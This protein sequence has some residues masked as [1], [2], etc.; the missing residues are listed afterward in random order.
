M[1]LA[2]LL[3]DKIEFITPNK[4]TSGHY[5]SPLM[6]EAAEIVVK[7]HVPTQSEKEEAHNKI[8]DLI[9]SDLP[10]WFVFNPNDQNLIYNVY[11][12]KLLPKT[13]DAINEMHYAGKNEHWNI[14]Q[15]NTSF[16]LS[17]MS[18]LAETCAGSQ[19]TTLTD[20]IDSYASLN[21][22]LTYNLGGTYNN[23]LSDGENIY[24]V[25]ITSF[26]IDKFDF[27]KLIKIRKREYTKNDTF[28]RELRTN[29]RKAVENFIENIKTNAKS[30]GDIIELHRVF[31]QDISDDV[32][33][34]KKELKLE[35][36]DL[37]FSKEMF[38]AII[39]FATSFLEPISSS[40]IG[41]GALVKRDLEYRK[42]RKAL[43]TSHPSSWLY[44]SQN[45]RQ[46]L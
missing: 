20:K 43:L 40:V 46:F 38:T 30:Q 29:Y 9:T 13:W 34:L 45:E 27:E 42:K 41:V 22:Y 32:E 36:W 39:T 21:R 1:K 4:H 24:T 28:L 7:P 10:D 25:P 19:K 2:L 16:G 11:P 26:A 17:I 5:D 15:T 14:Y 12:Q 3:Y 44:V 18:I 35:I 33:N 23:E 6:S 8:I 31:E 37:I